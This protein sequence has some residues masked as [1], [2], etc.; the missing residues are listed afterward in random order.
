MLQVFH[1]DAA[2]IDLDVAY[3]VM[4]I[5]VCCKCMF[6]MFHLFCIY[7]ASVSY[8]RWKGRSWCYICVQWLYT[9]FASICS[10]SK[11]R[12]RRHKAWPDLWPMQMW[13]P[14]PRSHNDARKLCARGRK[15]KLAS[16]FGAWM[17]FYCG[18][19]WWVVWW[20]CAQVTVQRIHS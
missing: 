12:I 17:S 9:Y 3:C 18:P 4:V 5:Y 1:L 19:F 20:E 6:Q 10:K 14:K 11:S 2:N 13:R 8:G 7:V 16:L 15:G